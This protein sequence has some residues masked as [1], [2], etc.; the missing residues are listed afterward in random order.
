MLAQLSSPIIF[1]HRG[2]S[3]Y[4]PE[5]TLAAFRLAVKHKADAVELDA[6]L[7][8]D[9]HVVVIH[10]QTVD[11]TTN[12]TGWVKDMPLEAL[13]ELEA[14]CHYDETFCDELIP[15][16]EEVFESVGDAI[17]INIELTNYA[18][19]RDQLPEKVASLVEHHNISNR[20][21]FSSFNPFVLRRIKHLLP[22]VPIGMLAG[23][24]ISGALFR[25]PLGRWVSYQALHP[26]LDNIN[27]ALI[28]RI[29]K[30]GQQINAWTVNSPEDMRRLFNWGV[31]GIITDDPP[32][33]YKIREKE[34][35]QKAD[36]TP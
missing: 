6:K 15:T 8:S 19:P 29:H 7:S 21:L 20:V 1:A 26:Y 30:S 22:Q 34:D 16:L 14:G 3:A 36:L 11:R 12:G 28:N 33:A 31:D 25:S 13:R 23:P 24:G 4:A 18:S 2:A 10:D 35:R 5:N 32:L 27:P 17:I 9:G